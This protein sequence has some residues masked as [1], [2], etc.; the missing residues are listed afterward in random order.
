[1]LNT[2]M[3]SNTLLHLVVMYSTVIQF[4]PICTALLYSSAPFVLFLIEY[5]ISW[6]HVLCMNFKPAW[7]RCHIFSPFS[8]CLPSDFSCLLI[9]L[10]LQIIYRIFSN[11]IRTSFCR[12]LKRKKMLVRGSNPHLSFN[13]PLPTRQTDWII[14]DLTNALTVIRLMRRV[15]SSDWVTDNDSVMSDDYEYDE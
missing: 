8:L 15:W 1:M 14:L 11:L 6:N 3:V 13:R 12:F 5:K 7:F 4:S 10:Y 2:E 9:Y